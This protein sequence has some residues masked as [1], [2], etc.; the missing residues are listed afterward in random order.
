MK[1][2]I[3]RRL[4]KILSQPKVAVPTLLAGALLASAVSMSDI[5]LVLQ[6]IG[7]IPIPF[8]LWTL[9]LAIAYLAGK[10]LQFRGFLKDLN[11]KVPWRSLLLAYVVGELTLTLPLGIYAQNYLLRRLQ[12]SRIAR[13]A[14]AST[15]MLILEAGVFFLIL[16]IL[17]VPGWSWLRTLAI[18]CVVGLIFF[19]GVMTRWRR[20]QRGTAG[21]LTRLHLP[22]K[23]V[24]EFL[25]SLGSLADGRILLRRGYLTALYIAA[26]VAAFHT[27]SHGVGVHQL[28]GYQAAAIYAFSLSIALIFGGITSQVGVVEIAGMGAARMYGYGFTEGLAMLLGFRL[29]WTACIWL[30][31]IPVVFWLKGDLKESARDHREESAD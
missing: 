26:L 20:L 5:P 3:L 12:G 23:A 21:L 10:G 31:C 6:R 7:K 29:I 25:R 14:A 4:W 24:L 9:L 11:I 18:I 17:G 15:L 13:T 19:I 8:L 2:K 1:S 16:A 28:G 22:G 30:I 27:I